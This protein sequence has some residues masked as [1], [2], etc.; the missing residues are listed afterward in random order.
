MV[1]RVDRPARN[2]GGDDLAEPLVLPRVLSR[3]TSSGRSTSRLPVRSWLRANRGS[4]ASSGT[5]STSH[6]L[7]NWPSL[8]AVMI[9]SPSAQ[10]SGSYGNRLGWAFPIRNGTTP[11]AT[12]ALDWFTRP[13]SADDMRLT[14]TC[15]RRPVS[16]NPGSLNPGSLNPGSLSRGSPNPVSLRPVLSEP[17]SCSLQRGKNA[18]RGVQSGHHVEHRDPCSI[19]RTAGVAGQAHQAGECLDDQVESGSA[20]PF[21]P[22]P[23]PEIEA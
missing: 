9:S 10:G 5:P 13:D 6:S 22:L 7:R 11:P 12:T 21:S 3:S 15:C 4:R 14:S 16:L 23:K 1:E 17:V 18:D 20:A 19:R 2:P 8:P